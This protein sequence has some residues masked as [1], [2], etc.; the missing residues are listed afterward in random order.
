MT[1]DDWV[2][3]YT[4]AHEIEGRKGV[5]RTVARKQLRQA[6]ADELITTMR[7]PSDD[8]SLLPIEFWQRVSPQEWREHRPEPD[9][10]RPD[11]D[12]CET[13]IMIYEADFRSW[14]DGP[15]KSRAQISRASRKRDLAKQ[16]VEHIWSNGIPAEILNK[17]IVKQVADYLKRQGISDISSD[18]ILRAAGK[19]Y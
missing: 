18:T 9:Y 4:A 7:A 12:G 19:K 10:Y 2:Y 3:F 17:Q 16:A 5:S 15:S 6:C 13:E 14:L 11:A 8:G 1:E